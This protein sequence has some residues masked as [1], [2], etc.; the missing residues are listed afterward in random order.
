MKELFELEIVLQVSPKLLYQF[1]STEEGLS[2]WF[3]DKVNITQNKIEFFWAKSRHEGQII[4]KKDQKYFKFSWIE[5]IEENTGCYVELTVIPTE[6]SNVTL[7]KIV[8]F[9]EL[10]EKEA[11]ILLWHTHIEKLKRSLGIWRE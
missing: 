4:A 10:D 11:N 7:L 1:I 3:A 2:K 9:S 8:D 5:D 6:Q